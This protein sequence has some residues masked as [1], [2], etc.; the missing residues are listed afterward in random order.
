MR[1][2]FQS[3][4]DPLDLNTF[5]ATD[6][7]RI[8]LNGLKD[9]A[10]GRLGWHTKPFPGLT[11]SE[12]YH[13]FLENH[14]IPLHDVIIIIQKLLQ[15]GVLERREKIARVRN[16]EEREVYEFIDSPEVNDENLVNLTLYSIVRTNIVVKSLEEL[17][18]VISGMG[19]PLYDPELRIFYLS[20]IDLALYKILVEEGNLT[21]SELYAHCGRPNNLG[22]NTIMWRLRILFETKIIKKILYDGIRYYIPVRNLTISFLTNEIKWKL[23]YSMKTENLIPHHLRHFKW[24]QEPVCSETNTLNAIL[25]RLCL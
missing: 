9:L 20:Y 15:K 23:C 21:F 7:E 22:T 10:L 11:Q 3:Q 5:F 12:I 6:Y 13:M 19:A 8:L 17:V 1:P 18:S 24:K 16:A 25:K 4:F 14:R 2:S